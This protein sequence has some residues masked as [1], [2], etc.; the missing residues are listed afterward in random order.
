MTIVENMAALDAVGA[1]T[2]ALVEKIFGNLDEQTA[3]TVARGKMRT[4]LGD[5]LI[6]G[7]VLK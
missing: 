6:R 1:K 5:Q 7:R 4:L 2:D 3:K